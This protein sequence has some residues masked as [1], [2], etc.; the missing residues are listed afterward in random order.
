[1]SHFY[2]EKNRDCSDWSQVA[3]EVRIYRTFV[4]CLLCL[5]PVLSSA[6]RNTTYFD[7]EDIRQPGTTVSVLTKVYQDP[8]RNCPGTDSAHH[9][10]YESRTDY[11]FDRNKRLKRYTE[12]ENDF[13]CNGVSDI[14]AKTKYRY[15]KNKEIQSNYF[16][17]ELTD[18]RTIVLDE[19]GNLVQT[20]LES[21]S[22]LLTERNKH[23][24]Q[25][26]NVGQIITHERYEVGDTVKRLAQ[27]EEFRY[28]VSGTVEK[29]IMTFYPMH[30]SAYSDTIQYWYD[31]AGREIK[32]QNTGTAKYVCNITYGT[33]TQIKVLLSTTSKESYYDSVITQYTDQQK[34]ASRLS[35]HKADGRW[36]IRLV[37]FD[38]I[39]EKP[40][41]ISDK[42]LNLRAGETPSSISQAQ[43]EERMI[44]LQELFITY[45]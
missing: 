15:E 22:H 12:Y 9:C 44:P 36:T 2:Q 4:I 11:R 17:G 20:S 34:I 6:Q 8:V 31:S 27:K 16:R 39:K 33:A 43:L 5:I 38:Y 32:K 26:D 23:V 13:T 29:K 24:Y 10:C 19:K 42:Q 18:T 1:M 7:K 14:I 3:R 41:H 28:T 45:K 37:S 35:Y 25:Y 30:S 21:K 40:V